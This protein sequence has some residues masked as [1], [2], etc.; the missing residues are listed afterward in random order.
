MT[1]LEAALADMPRD[2]VQLHWQGPSTH[3]LCQALTEAIAAL[4]N[5]CFIGV[6]LS[7]EKK[8][9]PASFNKFMKEFDAVCSSKRWEFS[10]FERI[11]TASQQKD[12]D[13]VLYVNPVLHYI[14]G[15][16]Q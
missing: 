4:D 14:S 11:K 1:P 13:Y 2:E 3:G 8:P 9:K 7:F 12:V 6:L 16:P 10:V 15:N 5:P